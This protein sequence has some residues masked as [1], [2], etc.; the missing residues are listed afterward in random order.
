MWVVGD[1]ADETRSLVET[2]LRRPRSHPAQLETLLFAARSKANGQHS[3]VRVRQHSSGGAGRLHVE[4]CLGYDVDWSSST[5]TTCEPKDLKPTPA[6]RKL[7]NDTHP[8]APCRP[9]T[10]APS[11]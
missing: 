2:A 8:K 4:P 5:P 1:Q 11:P 7:Q 6:T 9:L 10:R 3:A